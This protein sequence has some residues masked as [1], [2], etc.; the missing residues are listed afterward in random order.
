MHTPP[1]PP[2]N[3]RELLDYARTHGITQ[4]ELTQRTG[5]S[6]MTFNHWANGRVVPLPENFASLEAAVWE[7][8]DARRGGAL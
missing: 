3:A 6:R 4:A 8:I 1:L 7:A 2:M 5:L